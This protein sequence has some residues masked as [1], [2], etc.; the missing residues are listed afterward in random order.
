MARVNYKQLDPIDQQIVDFLRQDGRMP[1]REIARQLGVSESMVRK[2]AQR[3]LDS[4]W[5]R[6]LAVSDPLQLGVPIVATT[7]AKVS[8]QHLEAIADALAACPQV[9]YLG[10]GIGYANLVMESLHA[11]VEEL[12]RFI[13]V[14]LGMEGILSSET[15][16]VVTIKKSIWDWDLSRF[17]EKPPKEEQ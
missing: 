3:L 13:E 5:M 11:N 16:Q 10:T 17:Y 7:Y 6:I 4:G 12:Y 1:Y 2:R 14:K 8:P 9:R 15:M